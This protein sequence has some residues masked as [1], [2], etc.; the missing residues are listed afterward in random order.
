MIDFV[1][2]NCPELVYVFCIP[3]EGSGVASRKVA[4]DT[5]RPLVIARDH[6]NGIPSKTPFVDTKPRDPETLLSNYARNAR[7]C[8]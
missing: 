1:S 2:T 3:Y 8:P 6:I 5:G 7:V 4:D